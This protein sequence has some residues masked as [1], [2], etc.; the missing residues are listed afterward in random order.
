MKIM[1]NSTKR[2]L[3]FALFLTTLLCYC[4]T[5]LAASSTVIK[6]DATGDGTT[7]LQDIILLR[8]YFA[9]F[10]YDAG[11]CKVEIYEGADFDQDGQVTLS[12]L[13][14]LRQHLANPES[15]EPS[16][17][18]LSYENSPIYT[19]NSTNTLTTSSKGVA[20]SDNF[21]IVFDGHETNYSLSTFGVD[22]YHDCYTCTK[23][24][25][26]TEVNGSTVFGTCANKGIAG[27][28]VDFATP[29]HKSLV[30]GLTMTFMTTTDAVSSEIRIMK[31]GTTNQTNI[32]KPSP[33]P[34]FSGA[35]ED[36]KTV[37]FNLTA[38]LI[39]DLSDDDGYIRSLRF[40]FRDKDKSAIYIKDISFALS[41]GSLEIDTPKAISENCFYR[42]EAMEIIAN[43]IT[44]SLTAQNIG[45]DIEVKCTSYTQNTSAANG[46]ITYN[47][48]VSTDNGTEFKYEGCSTVI[49]KIE[50]EWLELSESGYG[51]TRDSKEQWQKTF[52]AGAILTLEN[53]VLNAAEGLAT[54][55]YAIIDTNT[56]I[57]SNDINWFAPQSLV[58][59]ND[60]IETL[61]INAALDYGTTLVDGNEY[62]FVVRGVTNNENYILHMDIKFTY[63]TYS[64][65]ALNALENAMAKINNADISC[66][67]DQINKEEHVKNQLVALIDNENV[68]VS[69]SVIEDGMLSGMYEACLSYSDKFAFEGT[70]YRATVSITY[71]EQQSE[72]IL[73]SP[74]DGEAN[75]RIASDET[76]RLWHTDNDIL[77]SDIYDYKKG[78]VCD[79]KPVKLQW[80]DSQEGATYTVSVSENIDFT[81]AWVFSVEGNSLDVYSLKSGTRYYWKV[82]RDGCVSETLTFVTEGGY[83]RFIL[84]DKVSNFRDLGGY[85]T[86]D[87][88][89]VKQG[90]AFRSSH[91]DNPNSAD[92]DFITNYLGV[93]SELDLRGEI[94]TTMLGE[95][96]NT[97]SIGIKS[98]NGLIEDDW[99]EPWRQAIS[100]FANEENYPIAY[101]CAIGRDR[102]GTMTILILG[103]I[104][105]DEDIILKDYIISKNSAMGGAD[106]V[107]SARLYQNYKHTI[108]LLKK[109]GDKDSTFSEC[110]E[111]YMLSIG[112]T[113]E[114]IASIRSIWL[115]D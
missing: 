91:L 100:V 43:Q 4:P 64:Q 45:A 47:V 23:N 94:T 13:V 39:D 35:T 83:P 99:K 55:E 96:V 51:A 42:G 102:T 108:N 66:T 101:H 115:E 37:D 5:I 29:I 22:T 114:E 61:F 14:L 25:G 10:D 112:V 76:V 31:Y 107:T 38:D 24:C 71:R 105:V 87:G 57:T 54:I 52:N 49:K 109:F 50:G 68:N 73:T 95:G 69:V 1:K 6:G 103:V 40:F 19:D 30:T 16:Y 59:N 104:G 106:G 2:I 44:N 85:T 27:I 63:K 72:I 17:T 18:D 28:T 20:L 33:Y 46:S 88:K 70:F 82:E 86:V 89:T 9:N 111:A 34:D 113:A 90:L 36:W 110:V 58:L 41:F 67:I 75:I 11:T 98:Y 74:R 81:D 78:E 48:T 97:Y 60:G 79:P 32:I 80:N 62:R 26:Y 92:I 8:Q 15:E 12:D 21:T 84:S 93:N 77:I 56:D 65:E 53:N 7:D 3:S